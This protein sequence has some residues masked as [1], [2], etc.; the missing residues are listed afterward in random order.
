MMCC[1]TDNNEGKLCYFLL[2]SMFFSGAYQPLD[3]Y[4][5]NCIYVREMIA[6]VV[7]KNDNDAGQ[8]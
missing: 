7:M 6:T 8:G 1:Y 5:E 3:V 4:R 2:T